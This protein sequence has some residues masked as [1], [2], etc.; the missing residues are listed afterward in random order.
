MKQPEKQADSAQFQE[1]TLGWKLTME[2]EGTTPNFYTYSSLKVKMFECQA[3][4]A[5]MDFQLFLTLFRGMVFGS[6]DLIS[7]QVEHMVG[8]EAV[9]AEEGISTTDIVGRLLLLTQVGS[10]DS[11][12]VPPKLKLDGMT[13]IC[14]QLG[15]EY[16]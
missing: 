5:H 2:L 10:S 15:L 14:D 13:T 4:S 1:Q 11:T 16:P 6:D 8:K 7:F 9:C 3:P 12:S